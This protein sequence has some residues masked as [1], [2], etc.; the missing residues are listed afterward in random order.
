LSS[1][2]SGFIAADHVEWSSVNDFRW[3]ARAGEVEESAGNDDDSSPLG[4]PTTGASS[5]SG[6]SAEERAGTTTTSSSGCVAID[7]PT[8]Q[9]CHNMKFL[10]SAGFPEFTNYTAGFKDLLDYIYIDG[11]DFEVVRVAPFPTPDELD[12]FKALP[13][14]VFPSDHLAVAVDLKLI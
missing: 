3:G 14:K 10:S 8:P 2:Y 13:S 1:S 4:E 11:N 12:E 6:K 9:L 5:S 7:A